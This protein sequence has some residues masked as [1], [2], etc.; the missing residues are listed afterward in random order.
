MAVLDRLAASMISYGGE[1]LLFSPDAEHWTVTTLAP[2][3]P[4]GNTSISL[5]TRIVAAMGRAARPLE[6]MSIGRCLPS[7]LGL[8][9]ASGAELAMT[10]F[11]GRHCPPRFAGPADNSFHNSKP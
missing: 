10:S 1:A 3:S 9:R 2:G 6:S 7:W 4:P 11:L 5:N 8:D